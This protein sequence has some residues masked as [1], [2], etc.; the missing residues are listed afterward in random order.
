LQWDQ[1][2]KTYILTHG[3]SG[4]DWRF[5]KHPLPEHVYDLYMQYWGDVW[6]VKMPAPTNDL[7][8]STRMGNDAIMYIFLSIL[9]Q[10]RVLPLDPPRLVFPY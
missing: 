10:I 5:C 9:V 3:A 8:E 6:R 1:L 7:D 2:H 4:V